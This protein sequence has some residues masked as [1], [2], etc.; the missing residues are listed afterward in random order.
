MLVHCSVSI[1]LPTQNFPAE[2]LISGKVS[3]YSPLFNLSPSFLLLHL[4]SSPS[5]QA[6]I[7]FGI[8]EQQRQLSRTMCYETNFC[9]SV[10]LYKLPEEKKI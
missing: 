6:L 1:G 7:S 4:H 2:H 9:N 8:R 5:P 10:K 3:D